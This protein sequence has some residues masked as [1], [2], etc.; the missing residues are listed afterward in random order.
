[1]RKS[2][3]GVVLAATL[4]P[5]SLVHADVASDV[6]SGKPLDVIF[7]EAKANNQDVL[8]VLGQVIAADS[9]KAYAAVAAAMAANPKQANAISSF[10][11]SRGLDRSTVNSMAAS[12][13]G[14]T[15]GIFSGTTSTYSPMNM[16]SFSSFS[17]FGSSSAGGGGASPR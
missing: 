14:N 3:L 1:M 10:A 7:A 8:D 4:L 6:Q 5:V 16:S 9:S 2:L 12:Y 17:G 15:G 11:I 13:T